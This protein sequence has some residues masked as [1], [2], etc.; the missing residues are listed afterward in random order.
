MDATE[1]RFARLTRLVLD[2]IAADADRA[3]LSRLSAEHPELV[4][5]VADEL[6]TDA[7]LKWQSGSIIE[8]LP[9]P[10]GR[11]ASS[12]VALNGKRS[13]KRTHQWSGMVAATL[14]IVCGSVALTNIARNPVDHAVADIVNQQD[15]CWSGDATALAANNTVQCGRLS[16]SSGEYT[17]R[18]RDGSTVRVVEQASLD[19]QSRMLLRLNHGRA[20]ANIARGSTGFTITSALVDVVDRGTEFGISV[21]NARADVVVFNG[22]VDVQ[23]NLGGSGTQKRLTQ[24]EAVKVDRQGTFARLAD[25]RRDVDGRWW[26]DDRSGPVGHVIARVSDNI[27]AG[28]GGGDK[29]VCYQTTFEG[30]RE[31]ALAY[32]DNPNHQWNGLTADGLPKFLRRADYIRTLNDYRYMPYFK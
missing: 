1:L 24:G 14:L 15:V 13:R 4:H 16:S 5:S 10:A 23:S 2:G 31:D 29:F 9:F 11:R 30:L 12:H 6:L 7:L 3:E 21:D 8:E 18:F 20:T 25:I 22:K 27:Q 32:S 28:G 17:L 26:S 19:I